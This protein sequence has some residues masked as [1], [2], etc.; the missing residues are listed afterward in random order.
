M[1]MKLARPR[2][3]ATPATRSRRPRR[4]SKAGAPGAEGERREPAH[5]HAGDDARGA[6]RAADRPQRPRH[7]DRLTA[8]GPSW[9]AG[10]WL[11]YL[12]LD[13]T[14]LNQ[15]EGGRISAAI[16]AREHDAR[17]RSAAAFMPYYAA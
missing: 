10:E 3:P 9:P 14:Y 8:N 11:L 12:W 7:R 4:C 13:A 16:P 5:A 1:S 17:L 2:C 6:D 15:R